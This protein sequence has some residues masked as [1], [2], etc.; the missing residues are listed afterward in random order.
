MRLRRFGRAACRCRGDRGCARSAPCGCSTSRGGW[1]FA[2]RR[3]GG[4]RDRRPGHAWRPGT[5]ASHPDRVP[6]EVAP[7]TLQDARHPPRS[8]PARIAD[9]DGPGRR[10]RR[11]G[12]VADLAR[13][14]AR[15]GMGRTARRQHDGRDGAG[16]PAARAHLLAGAAVLADGV[17]GRSRSRRRPR[18]S[19]APSSPAAARDSTV[20]GMTPAEIDAIEQT[21]E[22]R[23]LVTVVAPRSGVVVNRGVT[24][25][26]VG[27]SVDDAAHHRGSLARLGARR[28]AGGEHP[29][30]P[31]RA[32]PR[33]SI[34]RRPA[35]RRSRPAS[36]SSIRR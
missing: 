7:S 25:G 16:G 22:P 15:R 13:A 34:S 3:T 27:G 30:R 2:A 18:A 10:D 11:A 31:R 4:R 28:G 1:P 32:R 19:R 24:V 29:G 33:S 23:R 36:T 6:V 26:T 35:G 5:P 8:G 12:R 14:H 9:A 17:P 20:L 21:G